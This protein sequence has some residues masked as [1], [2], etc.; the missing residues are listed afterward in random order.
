VSEALSVVVALPED[1]RALEELLEGLATALGE[2]SWEAVVVTGADAPPRA[3]AD[4]RVRRVAAGDPLAPAA[5]CL[6][7]LRA[8]RG[9]DLAVVDPRE[10]SSPALVAAMHARLVAE[11]LDLVVA[12]R[13]DRPPA[14]L[15]LAAALARLVLGARLRDPL[16]ACFLVRREVFEAAAPAL[17]SRRA[18]LLPGLIAALPR[19]LR[20][21]EVPAPGP[22]APPGL[23][24]VAALELGDALTRRATRG[25]GILFRSAGLPFPA[26]QLAATLVAMT[27]NYALNNAVTYR[28]LRLRGLAFLRGLVSFYAV[29]AV[30]A[31]LNVA[32]ADR[33]FRLPAPWA[34]A[35]LAGALVGSVWNYAATSVVTWR[36]ARRTR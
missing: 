8:S 36:G 24:A 13:T 6:A 12:A 28:D 16:S 35:G 31:I 11:D 15:R 27:S 14:L 5:A 26:A 32:V 33:V 4:P 9:R 1:P 29:C 19:R 18:A 7:G 10:P 17:A 23:D 2:L 25:L 20:L 22:Q 3:S 21:A 34:A 30:G